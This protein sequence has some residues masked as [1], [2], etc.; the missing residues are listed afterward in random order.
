MRLSY[1]I[2][3]VSDMQRSIAFYRD[4]IG[5]PLNQGRLRGRASAVRAAA[6]LGALLFVAP[7]AAQD[8]DCFVLYDLKADKIVAREGG[9]RCSRSWPSTRAR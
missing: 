4:V 2:V 9:E 1:A 8:A 5:L 7:A 3:F 6:I